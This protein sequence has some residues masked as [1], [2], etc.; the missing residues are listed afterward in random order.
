MNAAGGATRWVDTFK[1]HPTDFLIVR[2]SWTPDSRKVVYQ[3]QNREQTFLDLNFASSDDGKS[4]TV[5][6]ETS[7]AWVEVVDNPTC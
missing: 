3:A 4:A 1:Y 6:R 7:K 2:V 5:L